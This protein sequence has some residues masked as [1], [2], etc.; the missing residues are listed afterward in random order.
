[1][2]FADVV[3]TRFSW[4]KFKKMHPEST[5]KEFP[6][7][8]FPNNSFPWR[9]IVGKCRV[10][11]KRHIFVVDYYTAE[12]IIF[13][14][15]EHALR[16]IGQR[17]ELKDIPIEYLFEFATAHSV[18]N[19]P[20]FVR[21]ILLKY[22]KSLPFAILNNY[23]FFSFQ[24]SVTHDEEKNIYIPDC[25]CILN[26]A[27]LG[28]ELVSSDNSLILQCLTFSREKVTYYVKILGKL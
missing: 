22:K 7:F 12:K 14:D 16:W 23:L 21:K 28:K 6:S 19:H 11:L 25:S 8:F 13:L 3:L 27:S 9:R 1:M 2:F 10:T 15:E 18:E 26:F 24:N 4:K 17:Q 5:K 20:H